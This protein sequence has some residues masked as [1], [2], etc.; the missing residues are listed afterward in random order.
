MYIAMRTRKKSNHIHACKPAGLRLAVGHG[1]HLELFVLLL[2]AVSGQNA[3]G[4]IK[5]CALV[6]MQALRKT[7][8]R[9]LQ[10]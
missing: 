7:P 8:Y 2:C 6:C 4:L 1:L 3:A 5:A 9:V 10:E